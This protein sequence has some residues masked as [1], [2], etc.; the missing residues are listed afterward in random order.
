M[1]G[2]RL[3]RL[4]WPPADY[5][6]VDIDDDDGDSDG[7]DQDNYN[8]LRPGEQIPAAML[9]LLMMIRMMTMMVL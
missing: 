4:R 7:N 8:C 2:K 6:D 1:T 3:N 5:Q 9:M